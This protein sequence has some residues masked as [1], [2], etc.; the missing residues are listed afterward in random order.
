VMG[1]VAFPRDALR[2]GIERG[3]ATIQFTVTASGEIKDVRAIRSTNQIFARSSIRLVNE[4][5]CSGQG[6][7]VIVNQTFSYKTE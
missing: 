7:D 1:D 2:Q 4:Y 6:R 3:E 5:K